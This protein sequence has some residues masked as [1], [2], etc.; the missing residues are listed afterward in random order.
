MKK[1]VK[2]TAIMLTA[3]MMVLQ[4]SVCLQ[5]TEVS[6]KALAPKKAYSNYINRYLYDSIGKKN[7]KYVY[8]DLDGDGVQELL[9]KYTV[10][11]RNAYKVYTYRAKKGKEIV[12]IMNLKNNGIS[13]MVK[14]KSLRV[15]KMVGSTK[16]TIDYR[17]V[18]NKLFKYNTYEKRYNGYFRNGAR[19]SEESYNKN[20]VNKADEYANIFAGAKKI[21]K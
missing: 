9:V 2:K 10:G 7:A 18:D 21:R 12:Q 4:V 6:A 15:T 19:I 13:M 1:I 5:A 20:V 11:G 3:I 16:V 17:K 14:G 8:R